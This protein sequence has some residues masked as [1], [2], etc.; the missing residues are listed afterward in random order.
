MGVRGKT[1]ISIVVE[2]VLGIAKRGPITKTRILQYKL[3]NLLE[4]FIEKFSNSPTFINAKTPSKGKPAAV[5]KKPIPDKNQLSPM[6]YPT[7]GGN[8]RFPAPKNIANNAKPSTK[9][10]FL[11]FMINNLLSNVI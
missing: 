10:S 3:L 1:P 11:L 4:I 2:P 7:E 6:L 9:I 5:S 8:I